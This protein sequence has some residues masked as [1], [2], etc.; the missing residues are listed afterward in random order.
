MG[1]YQ[2]FNETCVAVNLV[3]RFVIQGSINYSH[4]TSSFSC[5][6]FLWCSDNLVLLLRKYNVSLLF[7]GLRILG[8]G[9]T[10]LKEAGALSHGYDVISVYSNSWGPPDEGFRVE[11][12]GHLVQRTFEAGTM[13]V[14]FNHTG[15]LLQ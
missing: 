11:G 2:Q 4:S 8:E 14:S 15:T 5:L 13:K 1:H 7:A 3:Q 10:D 9:L 6:I 12:P